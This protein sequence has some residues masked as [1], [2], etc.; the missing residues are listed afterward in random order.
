MKKILSCATRASSALLFVTVIT[1]LSAAPLSAD[2]AT[3]KVSCEI[4]I[5]TDR[6]DA[7]IK[8]KGDVLVNAGEM[9]TI[10]WTGT[11]AT[12][13]TDKNGKSV[14]TSGSVKTS[15]IK[16]ATYTYRF[17]NGSKKAYCTANLI[18]ADAE[19]VTTST[20]DTEPTLTG[21]ATGMKTVRL[22]VEDASGKE[23]FKS[24]NVKTKKGRW[25]VKVH[26]ALAPGNYTVTISGAK[27]E[28]LPDVSTGKL[29]VLE[30]NGTAPSATGGTLAVRSIPLLAGGTS[31]AGASIPVAY[32]QVTNTGKAA[33]QVRGFTLK[34]TGSASTGPIIGF[35]TSDNKG[36]SRTTIGGTEGATQ[37]KNGSAFVPLQASIEAGGFRIFTLKAVMSK[38]SSGQYGKTLV[39]DVASVDTGAKVSGVLPIRGVTWTLGF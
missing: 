31:A 16:D 25:T 18:V 13:A 37:F 20:A 2:A 14:V 6:G 30:K 11:N 39:L 15:L 12:K 23:V 24:K 34:Q 7:D 10:A 27:D 8:K 17:T 19:L 29:T 4:T 3:K 5:T 38:L 33:A 36:G 32:I 28:G 26:K 1:S 9:V 21:A 22:T 35:S